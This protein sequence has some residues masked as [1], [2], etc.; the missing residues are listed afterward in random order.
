MELIASHPYYKVER[1]VSSLEQK[2]VEYKRMMYLYED[3]LVTHR[4]EFPAEIIFDMSHREM[5]GEDSLLYIHSSRGV[6][7]YPVK[8]NPS[9]FI[10]AFKK[11]EKRILEKEARKYEK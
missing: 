7:S 1:E 5:S 10:N 9:E 8:E 4:R 3:K 6:F 2:N 11:L